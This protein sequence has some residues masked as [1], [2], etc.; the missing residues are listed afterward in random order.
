[1]GSLGNLVGTKGCFKGT[2]VLEFRGWLI[3]NWGQGFDVSLVFQGKKGLL[4]EAHTCIGHFL[5]RL[6]PLWSLL[7]RGPLPSGFLTDFGINAPLGFPPFLLKHLSLSGPLKGIYGFPK[8]RSFTLYSR[9]VH[10]FSQ[11]RK[12]GGTS[13]P[14]LGWDYN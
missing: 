13:F 6:G 7:V 12:N 11:P 10:F 14:N 1:M 5:P 3:N 4:K 9:K 8:W 2:N